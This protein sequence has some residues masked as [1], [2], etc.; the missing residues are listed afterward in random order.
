MCA[1]QEIVL[2]SLTV[3]DPRRSGEPLFRNPCSDA[4][5]SI[6]MAAGVWYKPWS[7]PESGHGTFEYYDGSKYDGEW[8]GKK[9]NGKGKMIYSSSDDGTC[10]WYEGEFRNDQRQGRGKLVS[11]SFTY[12]GEF[13]A[14]LRHGSGKILY[15][16]GNA[17]EGE[18]N[19]GDLDGHGLYTYG[20][21]GVYFSKGDTYC[22]GF[23]NSVQH[24]D[25]TYTF[26]NG[27][28][29]KCTWEMGRC[30]EFRARQRL[31]KAAPDP[32][33]I[34]A[35]VEGYDSAEAK[36]AAQAKAAMVR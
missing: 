27:E 23:K 17:Y 15:S 4:T 32:A 16:D 6:A 36:D 12:E 2:L 24:G 30:P 35:R 22:G 28:T 3:S 26:F 33:S 14:G 11:S 21:E 1:Q 9:K 18:W 7:T 29:F 5:C 13:R 10:P 20:I 8:S 19:H 31:V 34:Q 25:G